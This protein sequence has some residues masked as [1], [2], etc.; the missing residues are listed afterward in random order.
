MPTYPILSLMGATRT[1]SRE[2]VGFR[3]LGSQTSSW[4]YA[5][6]ELQSFA[7]QFF[8]RC[9][10]LMW[11][12]QNIKLTHF[13]AKFI[14]SVFNRLLCR[15]STQDYSGCDTFSACFRIGKADSQNPPQGFLRS[16]GGKGSLVLA[17]WRGSE[18]GR[19]ASAFGLPGIR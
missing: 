15:I 12:L 10:L 14:F 11:H 7:G 19:I 18:A 8:S 1:Q 9:G 2:S 13:Q 3:A 4:I 5:E 16:V 6:S 17:P